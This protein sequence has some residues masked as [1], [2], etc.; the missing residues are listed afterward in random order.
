MK[1]KKPMGCVCLVG[2]GCGGKEWITVEGLALLKSCDAVVYDDLIDAGLLEEVPLQAERFYVGKRSHK[3]SAKQEDIQ[4]LLVRLAGQNKKVVRLKGGD[5]FVFGRGGEEIQYLND[6]QIPWKVVPGISS[7]LAIPAEAGIPVTHRGISRSIHIMTAHTKEDVLR[8]DLEQFANL[9]GTLIFLMGLQ[10]LETIVNILKEKGR[11]GNTPAA[12]LSG[13]NT[14]RPYKVVGTLENILEKA[15]EE[16]VATPGIIM[17]G[18]V[19]ALDLQNQ[20]DLPLSGTRIGLTGTDDFQEKLREKLQL[21][22]AETVSLMGGRCEELKTMIPWG[23][24][25]DS[26]RKWIVFTSV[27]G[28]RYFFYHCRKAGVDYRGFASCSF[29]VIGAA[30]G[31]ELKEYGFRADLCP[32][33]YTSMALADELILQRR[34]GE[35]VFLFCS[36]QGT[37]VLSKKLAEVQIP[38][39]RFDVYDTIFSP[40]EGQEGMLDFLLFG[41]AG[42][43]RAFWSLGYQKEKRTCGVCIGQVCADAYREC[44]KEEPVVAASATVEAM[45][46]VLLKKIQENEDDSI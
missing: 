42:G 45:T 34:R 29:A 25:T 35:E 7:A 39:H 19:V 36:R 33:E 11:N 18:D 28:I 16:G 9:E 40:R 20:V 5:P 24:I 3:S 22:G 4:A 32:Q 46:E 6:H 8:K 38:C 21:L 14:A 2:A 37:D 27:Q 1:S 15:N 31:K 10:S 12:I 13:G 44:F 30:T 41:S 17:I 43:V 26:K 23:Q